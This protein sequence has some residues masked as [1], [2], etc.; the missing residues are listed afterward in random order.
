MKNYLI[1]L[2]GQHH[3]FLVHKL[4]NDKVHEYVLLKESEFYQPVLIKELVLHQVFIDIKY[5]KVAVKC[6][7][8]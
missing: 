7:I 3:Q 5:P 1:L 6:F 8:R 4:S 2:I